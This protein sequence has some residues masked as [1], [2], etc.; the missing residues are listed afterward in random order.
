M[1]PIYCQSCGM[2]LVSDTDYGTNQDGSKNNE[3]CAFCFKDGKFTQDVTMEEMIQTAADQGLTGI[4]FTEHF[5]PDYPDT[6]ENGESYTKEE[7]LAGM[8]YYFP[9]LKRW[10]KD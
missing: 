9:Q 6:P 1:N 4:C 5:D 2:P 7:A 8:Q 10:K 3:Y